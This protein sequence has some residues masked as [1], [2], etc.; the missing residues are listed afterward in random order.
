M[1]EAAINVSEYVD[2]VLRAYRATPT[3]M[4]TVRQADRVVA[5]ELHARGVS[6]RVVENA[7]ILAAA[8]RLMRAPGAPPLQAV[9]SLAYFLPVIEE[10]MEMRT[11]PQYFEYLEHKIRRFVDLEGVKRFV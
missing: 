7:L 5:V 11:S 4:G 1:D 2:R 6:L 3:T 10:V 8:R 9:R